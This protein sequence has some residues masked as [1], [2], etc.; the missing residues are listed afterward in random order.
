VVL[1][2]DGVTTRWDLTAYPGLVTQHPTL[3]AGV[4]LRDHRRNRDD[5]SV[6][7]MRALS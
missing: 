5:A 3:I 7:A 6:V 1:H 4:L 2:S